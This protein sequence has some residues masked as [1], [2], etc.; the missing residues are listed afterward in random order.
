MPTRKRRLTFTHHARIDLFLIEEHIAQDNPP[1]AIA[2]IDRL[3]DCC[4]RLIEFPEAH[5]ERPDLFGDAS[6]RVA[7]VDDYLIIYEVRSAE[8]VV[9][10]IAHG[11]QVP[12]E[13]RGPA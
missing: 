6:M 8:V 11:A 12:G 9:L 5:P 13:D 1:N 3:R 2:F 10:R 7:V 4:L